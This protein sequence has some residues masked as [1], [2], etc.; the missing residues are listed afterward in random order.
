MEVINVVSR[1]ARTGS[2][3][4]VLVLALSVV[5]LGSSSLFGTRFEV[6][7]EIRFKIE[8]S[9]TWWW[10]CCSCDSSLVL[11]WRIVNSLEQAVYSVIHDAPVAATVWQGSWMQVDPDGVAIPAGQ[12]KLYVDTSVGTLSRCFTIYDPCACNWC[13][14]CNPCAVC[15]DVTAV[16]NCACRTTLVFVEDCQF[17]CFPLFQWGCCSCSSGCSS[18]P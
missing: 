7:E 12:Y 18:C 9:T 5:G 13:Y 4:L 16:T 10:G 1:L 17:G 11:G 2:L 15:E 6:G 8:D 3:V 14:S